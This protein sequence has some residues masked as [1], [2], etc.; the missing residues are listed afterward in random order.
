MEEAARRYVLSQV[1]SKHIESLNI[2]VEASMEDGLNLVVDVDLTLS[3]TLSGV[4]VQ[5]IADEAAGYA[6][7]EV[8][9]HLR[10]KK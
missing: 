1:P 4:E 8:E 2:T 9:K 6:F 5:K 7:N 3:S 10:G